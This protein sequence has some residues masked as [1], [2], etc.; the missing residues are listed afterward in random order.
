M[1]KTYPKRAAVSA[2]IFM[3]KMTLTLNFAHGEEII[4]DAN[5]L[6]PEIRNM[7]MMHGLKQKLVDAA[8]L[9]RNT[10]TGK[11]ASVED[12]YNAVKRVADRLKSPDGSWSE[13]R[14][15][16]EEKLTGSNILVR[17]LMKMTG[18]DEN[19]VKEYLSF[20]TKEE[21]AALKKNPKVLATIAELTAATV[22]G[23]VNTNELLGELGMD[24][25]AAPVDSPKPAKTS[26]A[27][28]QKP[29]LVSTAIEE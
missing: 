20:K 2:D 12:K 21:R 25:E 23:D 24:V 17:A 27:R 14:G 8:A 18:R 4:I 26:R 19:H 9:S 16:G 5:A 10:D 22:V 6:T 29:K 13:V 1:D 11:P 15:G 28:S 7:A 3:P